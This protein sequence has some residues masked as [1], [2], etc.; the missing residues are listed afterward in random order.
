MTTFIL[1]FMT[2]HYPINISSMLSRDSETNVSSVLQNTD[3]WNLYC[4]VLT[5]AVENK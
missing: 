4:V 3:Y 5:E 1:F 2:V